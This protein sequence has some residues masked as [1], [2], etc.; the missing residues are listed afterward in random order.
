MALKNRDILEGMYVINGRETWK[1]IYWDGSYNNVLLRYVDKN[2]NKSDSYVI[3]EGYTLEGDYENPKISWVNGMYFDADSER[4]AVN[5]FLAWSRGKPTK[6]SAK[7]SMKES[8]D[9][10][11]IYSDDSPADYIDDV[12][13]NDI[14]DIIDTTPNVYKIVDVT[15]SKKKTIWTDEY[16]FERAYESK[17]FARKSITEMFGDEEL[18]GDF[19][20]FLI[21]ECGY[22]KKTVEKYFYKKYKLNDFDTLSIKDYVKIKNEIEHELGIE[23]SKKS[24]RKTLK[25]G[26]DDELL[27]GSSDGYYTLYLSDKRQSDHGKDP[28]YDIALAIGGYF[29]RAV[30]T[31][32]PECEKIVM[33]WI[34][35]FDIEVDKAFIRKVIKE[36]K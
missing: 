30:R 12:T 3:A 16:G 9:I 32:D 4:G 36:F 6:K 8:I 35:L 13:K 31:D 10:K 28:H 33:K 5:E 14:Q 25:E 7:K 17:K 11:V 22:D 27:G 18:V 21:Y 20:D 26:I 29:D 34:D 19:V 24:S 15:G 1:V 2:G 23:E